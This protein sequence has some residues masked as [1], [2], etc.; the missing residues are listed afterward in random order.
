MPVPTKN[1]PDFWSTLSTRAFSRNTSRTVP[2]VA[3]LYS[4]FSPEEGAD[5]AGAGLPPSSLSSFTDDLLA[6]AGISSAFDFFDDTGIADSFEPVVVTS[7]ELDELPGL[8]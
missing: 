8:R 1:R 7:L 3:I 6:E 4:E 2:S 5:G